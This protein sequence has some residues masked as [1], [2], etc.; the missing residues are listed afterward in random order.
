L[1]FRFVR[2]HLAA[3][4][5]VAI[6]ISIGVW[7]FGLT[8]EIAMLGME[9]IPFAA[10]LLLAIEF[11]D[12]FFETEQTSWLLWCGGTCFVAALL[13]PD[14]VFLP[15]A[16]LALTVLFDWR[17]PRFALRVFAALAVS[18]GVP[19]ALYLGWKELYF[20][21]VI[22]NPAFVKMP[23]HGTNHFGMDSVRGFMNNH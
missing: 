10:A 14:S 21:S 6:L 13:R 4:R 3:S 17:R 8:A 19:L 22:P 18:F 1:I 16:I 12:R 20:G 11:M 5:P 15:L 2:R 23:G 9:T 7:T